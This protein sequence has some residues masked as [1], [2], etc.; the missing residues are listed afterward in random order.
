MKIKDKDGGR[1]V[2]STSNRWLGAIKMAVGDGSGNRNE[3]KG[4]GTSEKT[5]DVQP[6]LFERRFHSSWEK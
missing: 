1:E 4:K 6:A 5:D 3:I 2:R